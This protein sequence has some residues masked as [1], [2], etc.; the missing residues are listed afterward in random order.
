MGKGKQAAA[1]DFISSA[2]R[3]IQ[4]MSPYSPGKPIEELQREL[5]LSNVVK[6]AS[7]ENP[8]GPSPKVLQAIECGLPQLCRY[9]DANGVL[10]KQKLCEQHGVKPEQITL[11][12]GS[13]DVL[14]LIA[15][16]YCNAASEIIYSQH[17]FM[18]YPLA[19]QALAAKGVAVAAKNWCH[20]LQAMAAAITAKTK[21]IFLANPNN[22]T[23]TFFDTNTLVTFLDAVPENV[24]VVLDEAYSEYIDLGQYP[25]GVELLQSYRNLVVT[26]TF[27]KAYGLAALRV[28][29]CVANVEITDILNR[30]RQPFNVNSLALVAALAALED[31]QYLAQSVCLNKRG[32]AQLEAGF[33]KLGLEYIASVGNFIAVDFKREAQP[34]YQALLQKGVIVRPLTNYEMPNHLRI[35]VGLERENNRLLEA[36]GEVLR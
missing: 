32:L 28:G 20:D 17:G 5:G 15:R 7:N 9:P 36:L 2:N 4:A 18:V 26:R 1:I 23:G 25:N 19:A 10:L 30:I 27:S 13:N 33:K 11:G 22:P 16:A 3:S 24:I 14:E 12:N 34:I 21:L 29:Y 8:M 35:S 6:L 31:E